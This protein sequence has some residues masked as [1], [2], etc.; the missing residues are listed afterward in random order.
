MVG[1][2]RFELLTSPL[3]GVRSNQLSY[4]PPARSGPQAERPTAHRA[5][6]DVPQG[7][8]GEE[9][10]TAAAWWSVLGCQRSKDHRSPTPTLCPSTD[11]RA[12]R[13]R[14]RYGPQAADVRSL[15]RR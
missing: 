9:A 6:R 8:P 7:A 14:T 12:R 4:R 2:S 5:T 1:L 11:V 15:E 3:S 10:R 13:T